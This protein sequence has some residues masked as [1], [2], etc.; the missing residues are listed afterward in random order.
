ML[1]FAGRAD[2]QVKIR[3]Y[4]I[5]PGEIE[6]VLA[7]HP[8]VGQVAVIAR[9]ERLIAYVVAGGT[10]DPGGVNGAGLAGLR[11][12]LAERLPAHM[13]PAAFV[14]LDG[15]PLTV[16]GKLD[17]RALPAPDFAE[18]AGRGRGPGTVRE[19]VIGQVFAE[20]LGLESV[21]AED[22]FFV[23][24]GHSLLA[25]TLVER[26]RAR[27][28]SV[29]VRTLFA[30]PTVARLAAV[31]GREQVPVPPCLIPGP[32]T[33]VIT[34]EMVPLSGL[35]AGSAGCGGGDGGRRGTQH[36]GCLPAGAAAGR[37][38]LPPPAGRCWFP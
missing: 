30:E 7:G 28:V 35:T 17:R 21:G 5:E 4:R 10:G 34:A 19:E 32:G 16:N 9:E 2:D 8:A 27:G 18:G 13:I 12:Y 36:R 26:L 1:E 15:L 20:V 25:M 11:G 33:D 38:V 6:A 24:G 29:D 23:L 37:P 31:A 14:V 22:N 3:G